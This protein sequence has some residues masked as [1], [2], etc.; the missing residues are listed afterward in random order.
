VMALANKDQERAIY[1]WGYGQHAR[2]DSKECVQ[3]TG[4]TMLR[5]GYKALTACR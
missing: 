1:A 5:L 4:T 2:K 3:D